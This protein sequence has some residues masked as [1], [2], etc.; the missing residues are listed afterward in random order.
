MPFALNER[1][2]KDFERLVKEDIYE[3]IQYS[4]RAAPTVPILK[5][6]GTVR[7][8]G[9]YKQTIN[10]ASLCDK[11]PVPKT[12]DLFAT[13]NSGENFSKLD[14]SH[15]YQQLLLS[16]ESRPLLTVNTHKGLFQPK[17]LQFGIHSAS[18][19]FQREMEKRLE[20]FV[21][22]RSDDILMSGRNDVEHLENLKSVLSV[23]KSDGLRLK[24]R[25]CVFLQPE[26][27]YLGFRISKDSVLPLPEKVEIIKNAQVPKNVT[28]S[29][30]FLGFI[31]YYY[32]HLQNFSSFLEPLHCLL[33]KETPWKWTEKEN[34]SFNKAKE[35]QSSANLLVHYDTKKPLILSSDTSPYGL[36]AVLSHIMEDGSERPIIFSSRTLSKAQ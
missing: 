28:E 14:L 33:R 10:Q 25:K 30:S 13:L 21:K 29:K 24:F 16:P 34:N 6:D 31:N 20:T 1:I 7:I 32:R 12:E 35:L 18:G 4:K 3:P 5:D 19:I 8:C 27:T 26:V 15:A 36:G 17:R 22:V 9:D 23:L 11:Y 2:E